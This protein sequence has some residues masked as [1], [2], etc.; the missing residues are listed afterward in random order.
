MSP[1]N[2]AQLA[3][4]QI[5]QWYLCRQARIDDAYPAP[6]LHANITISRQLGCG[7]RCLA[8]SLAERLGMLVH[9]ASL[10]D[11]IARDKG[12][13]RNIVS[14]LDE[15]TRSELDIWVEGILHR[16][17]FS[18]SEFHVALTRTVS[19]LASAGGSIFLGRGANMIIDPATCLRLRVV[20]SP[21]TR[22]DNIITA[23]GAFRAEARNMIVESDRQRREFMQRFFGIDLDDPL[24]YDLMINMDRFSCGD[25][26][27]MV[28][29]TMTRQGLLRR[30]QEA[31]QS[32]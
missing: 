12:L 26:V 4:R 30:R 9:G 2:T 32:A 27:E 28:I 18:H 23:A 16:R 5:Q 3:Q 1:R 24:Y 8:E 19:T 10:I 20:A 11:T 15:R 29:D 13:S 22:I 21:E 6:P 14:Q 7:A 17:L 25:A 31:A